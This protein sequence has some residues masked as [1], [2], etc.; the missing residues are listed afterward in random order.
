[1]HLA[2]SPVHLPQD[3][4]LGRAASLWSVP[5]HLQAACEKDRLIPTSPAIAHIMQAGNFWEQYAS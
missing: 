1:M 3:D 4:T 5:C 2:A